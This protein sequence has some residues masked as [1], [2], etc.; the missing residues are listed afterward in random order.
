MMSGIDVK[1]RSL[2]ST[3]VVSLLDVGF[4]W[5]HDNIFLLYRTAQIFFENIHTFRCKLLSLI[6]NLMLLFGFGLID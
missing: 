2:G 4:A 3:G 5:K 6:G 1:R